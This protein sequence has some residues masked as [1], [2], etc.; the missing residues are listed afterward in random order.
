MANSWRESIFSLAIYFSELPN[1]DI[2]QV[3]FGKL[4]EM[5]KKANAHACGPSGV[6]NAHALV[7]AWQNDNRFRLVV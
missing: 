2:C 5:L 1:Y 4:S 7:E 6:A 3:N